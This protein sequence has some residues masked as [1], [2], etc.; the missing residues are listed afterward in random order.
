MERAIFHG[1]QHNSDVSASQLNQ[2]FTILR[3][4]KVLL[5]RTDGKCIVNGHGEKLNQLNHL[6][7]QGSTFRKFNT[8]GAIK[9]ECA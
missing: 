2:S 7:G 6:K 8:T 3:G 5:S 9:D 1:D 4:L